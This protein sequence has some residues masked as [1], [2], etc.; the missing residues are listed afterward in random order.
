M[1][2]FQW[3]FGSILTVTRQDLAVVAGL[4]AVALAVI[5]LLFRALV[6]VVLDEEGARVAGLP[7]AWLNGVIA[8]L[9]ALTIALSMRVVGI[10]LIA[11]LMVLP[12]T[13][14]TRLA[15]S[16]RSTFVLSMVV[17]LAS[18]MV[19]LVVAYYADVPPGGTIVLVAA[20]AVLTA[21]GVGTMRRA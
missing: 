5:V 8:G 19:G 16:L 20:V 18:S 12:V 9:A 10:L 14:A 7:V 3:L 1:S 6:A 2:L 13:A 17:G 4:G 11:A 15:W 21:T